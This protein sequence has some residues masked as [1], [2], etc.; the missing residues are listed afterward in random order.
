MGTGHVMRC[1]ALAEM[2]QAMAAQITFAMA[3]STPSVEKT[4]QKRGCEMVALK[5]GDGGVEDAKE[6]MSI[7]MARKVDW[8][9]AD[10]YHFGFAFQ[11]QV[12]TSGQRLLLLDDY[13]RAERYC[14][15]IILDQNLGA[16]PDLYRQRKSES[17]LLLGTRYCILRREFLA[18]RGRPRKIA[19][20]GR[21]ILVTL[22]GS[23]PG[24]VTE[25]VIQALN[26]LEDTQSVVV[27]GGSNPHLSSLRAA[28]EAN[29][30]IQLVL[31]ASNMSELMAEADLAITASG[32]TVWE[33]AFMGLPGLTVVLADNQQVVSERLAERGVTQNLGWHATLSPSRMADMLRKVLD[34]AEGRA[35]MS[36]RGR[37]LVDGLGSFRV[38]LHLNENELELRNASPTDSQR[39]WTWANRPEVRAVSFFIGTNSLGKSCPMVA[40]EAGRL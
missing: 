22:G 37:A 38:W 17:R 19:A 26:L 12:T 2:F 15:D 28:V 6:T 29:R 39:I 27:V 25:K 11:E 36:A 24:N 8:M 7:A 21:K 14:A 10:G 34:N 23:D 4:I 5:V 30:S 13:G 40:R 35:G 9:I 3:K 20:K 32:T 1:L 33:T 16:E 31:D 18:W